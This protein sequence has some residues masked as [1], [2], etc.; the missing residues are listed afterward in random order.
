MQRASEEIVKLNTFLGGTLNTA[1]MQAAV[2]QT[3]YRN[4]STNDH[5][6]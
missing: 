4:R 1:A 3:L 2:D 6:R 5:P